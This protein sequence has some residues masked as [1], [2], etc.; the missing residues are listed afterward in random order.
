MD[1]CKLSSFFAIFIT[2]FSK[3]IQN[4]N[5][6]PVRNTRL[7]FTSHYSPG[8][9]VGERDTLINKWPQ[10]WGNWICILKWKTGSN[11]EEFKSSVKALRMALLVVVFWAT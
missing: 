3:L 8:G 2:Y 6:L 9:S 7:D 1:T 10:L 4:V 11:R 5:A